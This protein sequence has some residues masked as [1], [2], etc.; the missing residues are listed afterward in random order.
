[1]AVIS[2][3]KERLTHCGAIQPRALLSP[4]RG[5][6]KCRMC[7]P[8]RSAAT[9]QS[10]KSANQE[11]LC[12]SRAAVSGARTDTLTPWVRSNQERRCWDLF[13]ILSSSAMSCWRRAS[14]TSRSAAGR[15]RTMAFNFTTIP[16]SFLPSWVSARRQA[17]VIE[18]THGA[19]R[20]YA[21]GVRTRRRSH[22]WRP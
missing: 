12:S 5:T 3:A 9:C 15:L 1:M 4:Y 8:E 18:F 6:P 11:R 17:H 21:G 13:W 14:T 19:L 2:S 7:W 22:E 10:P 16:Y 20:H